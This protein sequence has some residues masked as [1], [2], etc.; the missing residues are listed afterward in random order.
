V[1][2]YSTHGAT[3]CHYCL[4]N[5]IELFILMCLHLY[6]CTLHTHT[7]HQHSH[8]GL[9]VL[10]QP[11]FYK[12][13]FVSKY[14]RNQWRQTLPKEHLLKRSVSGKYPLHGK[15][16]NA[17]I[18]AYHGQT[19]H[20]KTTCDRSHPQPN[21]SHSC[22]TTMHYV[23]ISPAK[24]TPQFISRCRSNLFTNETQI[25]KVAP[26]PSQNSLYRQADSLASAL[27]S[28]HTTST[29]CY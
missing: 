29:S 5:H 6:I 17:A 14:L 10:H 23:L 8:P 15:T 28:P 25:N 4:F 21:S 18:H 7:K 19:N 12:T 16:T 22:D 20:T 1:H 9:Y 24:N 27:G 13:D 26:P 3:Y 11:H 2:L